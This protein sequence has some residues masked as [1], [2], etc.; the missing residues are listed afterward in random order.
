MM[1]PVTANSCIEE[2]RTQTLLTPISY[3]SRQRG[4][5]TTSCLATLPYALSADRLSNLRAITNL[6][7]TFA[8]PGP[9][10]KPV[11]PS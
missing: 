11:W 7:P 8:S 1:C 2:R 5:R 4:A 6:G 3:R 9:R 10:S